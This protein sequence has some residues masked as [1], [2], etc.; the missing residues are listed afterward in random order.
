[1]I[2]ITFLDKHIRQL[3]NLKSSEETK[4]AEYM[5]EHNLTE[6]CLLNRTIAK[7]EKKKRKT[8]TASDLLNFYEEAIF[9]EEVSVINQHK[10]EL[11]EIQTEIVKLQAKYNS[12]FNNDKIKE[13][14]FKLQKEKYRLTS[15]PSAGYN[16]KV[17][18]VK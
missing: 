8:V 9:Q 11:R 1:M 12:Y 17:T 15:M 6:C 4:L 18:R 13:L 2:D 14:N 5:L 7:L 3:K 16:V 10:K